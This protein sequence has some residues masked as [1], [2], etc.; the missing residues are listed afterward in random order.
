MRTYNRPQP[1]QNS[2]VR[3]PQQFNQF[4]NQ[5]PHPQ[6]QPH[7]QPQ[8]Q[9]QAQ[10]TFYNCGFNGCNFRTDSPNIIRNHERYCQAQYS[11]VPANQQVPVQ[12]QRHVSVNQ[13]PQQSRST[14]VP[15]QIAPDLNRDHL[16]LCN[17]CNCYC[18]SQN[19]LNEHI[20]KVHD[21]VNGQVY[22]Y[23]C[24]YCPVPIIF[25]NEALL[26]RHMDSKHNYF[27]ELCNKRYP[28]QESL[29]EHLQEEHPRNV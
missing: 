16:I 15:N 2:I 9:Y 6:A 5:Q 27:C 21:A 13:M 14:A 22:C 3:T 24:D 12:Q 19:E 4:L 8:P 11:G 1:H 7:S 18:T 20:K 10:K 29:S 25:E 26:R 28:V 17:I 23:V